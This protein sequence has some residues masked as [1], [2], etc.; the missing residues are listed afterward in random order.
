MFPD[1][2][3]GD[4]QYER[5]MMIATVVM[6]AIAS[7]KANDPKVSL[8]LP[9]I[10]FLVEKIH[11]HR[12]NQHLFLNP[13]TDDVAPRYSRIIDKPMCIRT[14]EEKITNSAYKSVDEYI[15]DVSTV[16]NRRYLTSKLPVLLNRPDS[17]FVR[18]SSCFRIVSSTILQIGM[19]YTF[20]PKLSDKRNYGKKKSSLMYGPK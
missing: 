6:K 9:H 14:M 17:I 3:V 4:S 2:P 19:P 15:E 13:V 5:K 8:T 20:D 12:R 11:N 1:L 7:M 18:P 10:F 16:F